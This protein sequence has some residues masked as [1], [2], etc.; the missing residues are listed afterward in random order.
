MES[1]ELPIIG[2]LLVALVAAVMIADCHLHPSG[3]LIVDF[4]FSAICIP[5]HDF[6]RRISVALCNEIS[7][8]CSRIAV[9]TSLEDCGALS[10]ASIRYSKLSFGR[11]AV[12]QDQSAE[13]TA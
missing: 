6:L 10:V 8:H 4:V 3:I 12:S 2:S 11:A 7:F 9:V 5:W 1:L 13:I